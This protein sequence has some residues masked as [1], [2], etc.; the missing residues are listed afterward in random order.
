MSTF[1]TAVGKVLFWIAATLVAFLVV[2]VLGSVLYYAGKALYKATE[3]KV[4]V[5]K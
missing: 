5:V 4:T 2:N 3:P 1:A